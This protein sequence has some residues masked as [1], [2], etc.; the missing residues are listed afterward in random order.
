MLNFE[1]LKPHKL[2]TFPAMS[3]V[4]YQELKQSILAFG[5]DDSFPI[6][7]YEGYGDTEPGVIDGANRL[8]ACIEL[9]EVPLLQKFHG[10]TADAVEFILRTNKRR[11]LTAG[12]KAAVILDMQDVVDEINGNGKASQLKGVSNLKNQEVNESA[13][14]LGGVA[15]D[16][17]DD[18]GRSSVILGEMAGAGATTV[19][20]M[21]AIKKNSQELYD[22]VKDGSLSS[23]A[24]YKQIKET[25]AEDKA[26]E[27]GNDDLF[28]IRKIATKLAKTLV[29][30][31]Y[32]EHKKLLF[33]ACV[34]AIQEQRELK[35][36]EANIKIKFKI[37]KD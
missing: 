4:E 13:E 27:E 18:S 21:K 11:N 22:A 36:E 3:E 19:K 6:I 34:K 30:D 28:Y 20:E 9:D 37:V 7:V 26:I 12:Q 29:E 15:S 23:K 17:T 2:N 25:E 31:A 24:V 1:E 33:N 5:Y 14:S 16:P 35:L 10:T 8:R 32:K